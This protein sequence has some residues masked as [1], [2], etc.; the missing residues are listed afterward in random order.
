MAQRVSGASP[1]AVS[2]SL[3][4]QTRWQ[5]L[6]IEHTKPQAAVKRR[7]PGDIAEGGEVTAGYAARRAWSMIFA[8]IARPMP[9]PPRLVN[10]NLDDKQRVIQRFGQQEAASCSSATATRLWP[11]STEAMLPEVDRRTFC[12]PGEVRNEA[13]RTGPPSVRLRADRGYRSAWP[14]E[15]SLRRL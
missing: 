5:R 4:C 10:G 12:Q 1:W 3:C 6:F 7:I 11:S 9:L 14:G 13:K 8:I 2:L 15:K